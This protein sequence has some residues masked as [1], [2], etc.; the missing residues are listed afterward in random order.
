MY[1]YI[2]DLSDMLD[3]KLANNVIC[4]YYMII[5]FGCGLRMCRMVAPGSDGL[6][7]ANEP[8]GLGMPSSSGMYALGR[9]S[10]VDMTSVA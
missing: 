5:S 9:A 4:F 2:L 1:I 6:N 10:A 7:G 3:L 8:Y